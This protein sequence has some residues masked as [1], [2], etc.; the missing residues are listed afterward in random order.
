MLF[1]LAIRIER[2]QV[3]EP[4]AAPGVPLLEASMALICRVYSPNLPALIISI[5]LGRGR[6][7]LS[8]ASHRRAHGDT[9]PRT[10][11]APPGEAESAP[12]PGRA[13]F[14]AGR[15]RRGA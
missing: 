15:T 3:V 4:T 14:P 9:S 5:A 2:S 12:S 7:K 10:P 8:A 6:G 1:F 11:P 13:A